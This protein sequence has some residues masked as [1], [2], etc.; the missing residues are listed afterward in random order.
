MTTDVIEAPT[1]DEGNDLATFGYKQ[2]LHRKMGRFASFAAGFSF[3]SVLTAV[4]QLA[5]LGYSFGGPAFVWT[6]PV[7]LGGQLLVAACFAELAARYPIS[8]AIYQ[9]SSRLANPTYGWFAGWIMIVGQ[10]V[11]MTSAAI[12]LQVVLP[13][14]WSGFQLVGGDPSPTSTSG[15]HN[16]ILLAGILMAL[17]TIV[18]IIGIRLMALINNIGVVSEITGA[19]TII[20]LL[21]AH[22]GRSSDVLVTTGNVSHAGY[23]GALL[24]ASFTAA[25]V[26]VGFDSASE[27]SEETRNA[28][29]IA[30]RTTLRA[31]SAAGVLGFGI[32][33]A[34]VLA[35][36][37][38]T[39]GKLADQGPAYVVATV[40][41]GT[42]GK[43]LLTMVAI[44]ICV[45]TLAIQTAGSRMLFSMA[46]D[47]RT[48][49]HGVLSHVPQRTGTP[50]AAAIAIGLSA[51][52]VLLLNLGPQAAF[53]A[54]ESTCIIIIYLAYLMVTGA[55]LVKRLRGQR[56]FNADAVDDEG[57]RAFSM[58]RAGVWLNAAAVAYG[59]AMFVNLI[60]PRRAIYDPAGGHLYLQYFPL[61]FTGGT[62]VVG[63]LLYA[64]VHATPNRLKLRQWT[65]A[66]SVE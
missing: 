46:R 8:G 42:T 65:L 19:I 3:I 37:S 41:S 52:A 26:L 56:I 7:V 15:A 10:I 5:G 29:R 23:F 66:P 31:L 57:H 38:L 11:V 25:Y 1:V 18:N 21:I 13:Q 59:A 48:L 40:L 45:A 28:R 12:A 53:V 39:D 36:P 27:M 51:T 17:T 64:A 22:G 43:I 32:I 4:F 16:A 49:F 35:A 55:M 54:M 2:Q 9:W 61:M 34:M 20:V 58:G 50:A 33:V 6:W 60:W 44:A 63:A 14:I 62:I 47:R 30:P 24:C